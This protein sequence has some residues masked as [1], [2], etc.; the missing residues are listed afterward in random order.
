MVAFESLLIGRYPFF[1]SDMAFSQH[2]SGWEKPVPEIKDVRSSLS[3]LGLVPFKNIVFLFFCVFFFLSFL[4][5]LTT[6]KFSLILIVPML[7]FCL[8]VVQVCV[9]V[10]FLGG[11]L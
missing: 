1:V 10:C 8:C 2:F 6:F 9:C 11:G 7:L 4:L 3:I 5:L